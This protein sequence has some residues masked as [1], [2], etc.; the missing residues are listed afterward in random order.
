MEFKKLKERWCRQLAEQEKLA[1]LRRAALLGKGPAIFEKYSIRK[2][3]LFGS[4]LEKK[5][6][7]NSDIDILVMPLKDENY[8]KLRFDLET[9]IGCPVD[10]YSQTDEAQFV[11]KIMDRGE[12]V[13]ET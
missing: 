10:L 6:T 13:Y 11:K 7:V 8:W 4:I 3:F 9:A 1:L 5:C 12:V 2:V